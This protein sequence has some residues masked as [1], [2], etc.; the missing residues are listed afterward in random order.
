VEEIFMGNN[1]KIWQSVTGMTVILL[2]LLIV[3]S[4]GIAEAAPPQTISSPDYRKPILAPVSQINAWANIIPNALASY[5]TYVPYR[6]SDA[7]KLGFPASCG[8]LPEDPA[9]TEDCYTIT[10]K[11]FQQ[12]LD[13][14][15]I[16]GGGEGLLDASG[17]P[18]GAITWVHGYGS[19]GQNWSPPGA[20]AGVTVTGNAPAPFVN[21]TFGTSGIWHFPAPTVKATKG[22]PVRISWLNELPNEVPTG[23]DPTICDNMPLNCY[24]YNRIVTHV[25]GAHVTPESDGLPTA[26]FTPGFAQKG[27]DWESTRKFGPEGT[28]RYPMDQEAGTIWYHDHALGL[29]HNNT[30]MGMA[31]FF[32]ITDNNEKC[33]QGVGAGCTKY[34]PTG[35]YELGFALQDRVFYEDGQVAMPD[36]PIIDARDI[37]DPVNLQNPLNCTYTYQPDGTITPND[38]ARCANTPLF[39]KDP[40]DGH[41]IPYVAAP[42]RVALLAT[43]ATLEFFGNLPVVNGVVNGKYNVEPRVY[44]MRFI[45]GTDSRTWIL[46]LARND[47]NAVIPFWQIGTEQGFLNNPVNRTSMVLMPGER[48]DVLVDFSG[49]PA[50]TRVILKN[51]GPDVPFNNND[52]LTDPSQS[53]ST[54]IPQVM[55][56]DVV[57]FALNPSTGQP[58]PD[59]PAPS[60]SRVLNDIRPLPAPSNV[61]KV[62]LWEIT[63]EFGRTMPTIDGRGFE[64]EMTEF[65]QLNAVEQWD[66]I[67]TTVD[68]HPMHLHQVAF[69]LVN[70]ESI[71]VLGTDPVSGDPILNVTNAGV[72]PGPL[73][74]P[75]YVVATPSTIEL[76]A[77]HEAG[78]KDTIMC[79][80]GKVTRVIAKFD[81]PGLYVWHCHI[82]S[83]EEHD[84]MRPFVVTT[85]ADHVI[86]ESSSPTNSQPSGV[87][88]PVTFMARTVTTLP[89]FPDGSGFEYQFSVTPP[90]GIAVSQPVPAMNSMFMA[91]TAGYAFVKEAVW[92]PPT[93][94]GTYM[95]KVNTKAP[96]AVSASNPVKSATISYVVSA[97]AIAG[98]TSTTAAG[99][100][101][102]G[103]NINV[104]LTFNQPVT[105][106]GLRIL[107]SSGAS[108][109]TGTLTNTAS[110][111]GTYSVAP[112][113]TV[114]ALN[115]V[116]VAGRITD[117]AGNSVTNPSVPAGFNIANSRVIVIDAPLPVPVDTTSPVTIASPAAG[118]YFSTF[119]V[120]LTAN[121]AGASIYY[122]IDG[123]EPVPGSSLQYDVP[124]VI[125]VPSAVTL[126]Y[127]AVDAAGNRSVPITGIYRARIPNLSGTVTINGGAQF[128]KSTAVTLALTAS[129]SGAFTQMQ[130]S[131]DGITYSTP[132]AFA[133]T[134]S[135]TLTAGE[136]V[137]S[138]FA[139]FIDSTGTAVGPFNA[140]I[141]LDT[142]APQTTAT[143]AGG[144]FSN[145]VTVELQANESA[146][147]TYYTIDGTIPTTGS[148]VYIA[149][150]VFASSVTRDFTLRY[151]SVDKAGNAEEV[152]SVALTLHTADLHANVAINNGDLFTNQIGV[153][154][155]LSATDPA[156]VTSMQFSGDGV[157]YTAPEP[158]AVSRGWVLTPGDGL[159][160][161][162][163]KFTD[164]TG[165]VYPPVTAQITL[166]TWAPVTSVTPVSGVYTGTVNAVLSASETANIYYTTDGSQPTTSSSLYT[167]PVV[168]SGEGQ[169]VVLRYFAVDQAGNT[170]TEK[171]A[172]YAF[173]HTPD[174]TAVTNINGGA[175]YTGSPNVTLSFSAFD[176]IGGG[177]G[178]MSFSNDGS[179]FTSPEAYQE[180]RSYPWVL[181]A[182]DG[183][184]SVYFRFTDNGV[185]PNSYTFI[186][187]ITLVSDVTAMASG[188]L[189]GDGIVDIAD[190]LKSLRATVGLVNLTS[191]EKV[192]GDVAPLVSGRPS[193]DGIIDSGD[194]LVILR[195]ALG[196]ASY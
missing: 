184:K 172:T 119:S 126:T 140:Q 102:T 192:R 90:A 196:L 190:A 99:V 131:N 146:V 23:F 48:L 107:L 183:V 101:R 29:T 94:P 17:A 132:V 123:S 42:G 193:P 177:V 189:N 163:V 80:P 85:A 98:V 7:V 176:A 109:Y 130:F 143:P 155:A 120:T 73:T 14:H 110:F 41:L 135:W 160:T 50:G 124:I 175:P 87:A 10:V 9:S 161:V 100:Y 141:T 24:P 79:P 178:T 108:I 181:T 81:I 55:A 104:T 194:T 46:Q 82:L 116:Q 5:F 70:R 6:T 43:S 67:N 188:D 71:E 22:R 68:T 144:T 62:S 147:T 118:D 157:T 13:L 191:N 52:P 72:L 139:R 137:K 36:A 16:F 56:F 168:I 63:D 173:T 150:V 174:M 74:P 53:P 47:N 179:T 19:G 169:I 69:Q 133:A 112:G 33:L 185:V 153:I 106:T 117:A 26:W 154:L 57:T 97:P 15:G 111:S 27:N 145:S 158:F 166:D 103:A 51:L 83:H 114:S 4:R 8:R 39:M 58:Y 66:I 40:A 129:T 38:L 37:I 167:V 12:A 105:S 182:G 54:D 21:N 187:Q 18:F 113:E 45:G 77:P 195:K 152:K 35:D 32:P 64:G 96:G 30:N 60:A 76:P 11:K 3:L 142:T 25:H 44:R 127:M 159:K 134:F 31:G 171:M 92:T 20:P 49:I 61:K 1:K 149:P 148:P 136:G 170:E 165:T 128:T 180:S 115:V 65:V 75:D 125:A 93:V 162:Y 121:E 88:A 86:L 151:F 2:L 59:V 156:G 78:W 91:S 164:G 89:E 28:Y 34:L 95:V 138:V 84:M 186:S 122:T